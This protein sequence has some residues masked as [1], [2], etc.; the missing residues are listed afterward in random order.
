MRLRSRK[1]IAAFALLAAIALVVAVFRDRGATKA[2]ATRVSADEIAFEAPA[3]PTIESPPSADATAIRQTAEDAPQ[4]DAIK[5]DTKPGWWLLGTLHGLEAVAPEH[6]QLELS[7]FGGSEHTSGAVASDGSFEIDVTQLIEGVPG[8]SIVEIGG[9]RIAIQTGHGRGMPTSDGPATIQVHV[10]H[11]FVAGADSSFQPPARARGDGERIEIHRDFRCRAGAVVTGRVSV[12]PEAELDG[13]D[14]ALFSARAFERGVASPVNTGW[15]HL[16]G[17]FAIAFD[18][19]G[20][21]VVVAF[22]DGLAP[23]A[24]SAFARR[25]EQTDVGTLALKPRDGELAGLVTLPGGL[26]ADG[27]ELSVQRDRLVADEIA[28]TFH[29]IVRA[30]DRFVDTQHSVATDST[31]HF[32]FRSLAPG[33]WKLR[34]DAVNGATVLPGL[35]PMNV[36]VPARDVAV[37]AG[38]QRVTVVVVHAGAPLE[39]AEIKVTT[40]AGP[41]ELVT[42]DAG[43][44]AWIGA[45]GVDYPV[46]VSM[47][48]FEPVATTIAAAGRPD[49]STVTIEL[50]TP[51]R[52]AH[53]DVLGPAKAFLRLTLEPVGGGDAI[54]RGGRLE[55]GRCAF[56]DLPPGTY[57]ARLQPGD[58]SGLPGCFFGAILATEEFDLALAAGET[59]TH[60][61]SGAKVG[62]LRIEFEGFSLEPADRYAKLEVIAA[63][64]SR[65]DRSVVVSGGPWFS[66]QEGVVYLDGAN[67]VEP[68]LPPGEY[69]LRFVH[70]RVAIAPRKAT[71]VA[72]ETT[73]VS[74]RL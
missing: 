24:T 19:E 56:D 27:C 9:S 73:L 37:G 35:A 58:P 31:G 47:S 53:L 40:P 74:I 15:P 10:K 62:R 17:G 51:A 39:W 2:P 61:L 41:A 63:D 59:A 44:A 4:P 6:A 66:R 54:E 13:S 36:V 23:V 11:E 14:V 46:T 26:S 12:P 16:D 69:E 29:G 68:D 3:A 8:V 28:T 34:L 32:D 70:P 18:G 25:G 33:P 72:G 67:V 60:T 45:A 71:V 52:V 57:R 50:A 7:R 5:T 49:D 48:G 30:G 20:P 1:A 55:N 21:I 42:D 64:G 22:R 43:R 65:A 38:L